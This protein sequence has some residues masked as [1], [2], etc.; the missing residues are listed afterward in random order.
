MQS[1]VLYKYYPFSAE[2][3][4]IKIPGTWM[5]SDMVCVSKG[6]ILPQERENKKLGIVLPIIRMNSPRASKSKVLCFVFL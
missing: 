4:M 5:G 2:Y 1:V 3:I 6:L